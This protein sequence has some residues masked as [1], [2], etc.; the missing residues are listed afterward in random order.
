MIIAIDKQRR[1]E[2]SRLMAREALE[3]TGGTLANKQTRK[4]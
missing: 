2:T 4:I 3:G 1:R